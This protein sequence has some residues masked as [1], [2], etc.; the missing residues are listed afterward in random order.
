MI[1]NSLAFTS[2]YA[3]PV[4]REFSRS[5]K[6]SFE[7]SPRREAYAQT[8]GYRSPRRGRGERASTEC[9]LN[10]SKTTCRSSSSVG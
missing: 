4:S 7:L 6:F 2:V 8:F 5:Q 9:P 1:R 10:R 3:D